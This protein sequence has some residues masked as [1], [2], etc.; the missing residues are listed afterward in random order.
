[1]K[2]AITI[3]G[4]N[5]LGANYIAWSPVRASVRLV[6][7]EGAVNPVPTILRNRNPNKGGQVI[8]FST[9]PGVGEAQIQVN[10]PPD[11]TAVEF[12]VGGKFGRPSLADKDAVI[13]A[14]LA[15]S[16][17][18]PGTPNI[19]LATKALMVRIRKN[20]NKLTDNE[21]NR[22]L[23]AFARLNNRGMG[24]FSDFRNMHTDL[25]SGE[26][27]GNAGF[28]PWHRAYLLDLERE[29]QRID[30]TVALPYWR[31]DQPAPR[32]FTRAFI[33]LSDPIGRVQFSP[34]NP[35]RF[36][37]TDSTPGIIRTPGFNTTTE[38]AFVISEEDTLDL[39]GPSQL[40]GNF[41]DMEGNPHGR[42]HVSFTGSISLIDTA[43]KDP[44]FFLLHANV[45][46]LWAKW[47]WFNHRFDTA[48]PATYTFR[49]S[50][51]DPG[52]TTIGH[53]LNDTMWPWNQDTS[54]PRPATA[55]GG[56]FAASPFA[57]APG[58]KPKVRDMID[59]QGV[60]VS[61][62]RLGFDY[63]DVP[64]EF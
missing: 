23:S 44:L 46:R 18:I 27:H 37:A 50:A 24:R 3:E 11:G 55:P 29:L 41:L 8:F 20:A 57:A 43:A 58:L 53:N 45:D 26:A 51:G 59:H 25:T 63:D 7:A 32:L 16:G 62:G 5:S 64:L 52:S 56:N 36:W 22:F 15:N 9:V 30:P 34:T 10:L 28:L 1:M 19:V 61:G 31:F 60:I 39:G 42:A 21:R 38:A 54:P 13:Q 35:L 48:N 4:A 33:G 2:A 17:P 14:V 49:G 47:Q 40:Y 6:D 12:F